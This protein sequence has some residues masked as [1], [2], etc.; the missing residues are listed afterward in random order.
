MG[1]PKFVDYTRECMNEI[2]YCPQDTLAYCTTDKYAGCPFYKT[3]EKIGVV[4]ENMRQC[5]VCK[6][7]ST[8]NFEQFVVMTAAYCL[9]DKFVECQRYI[10]K[11]QG[12]VVSEL[13]LPDGRELS[14]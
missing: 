11:K 5:P 3:V 9:N 14:R 2:G 10:L 1:C 4:C 12:R 8:H 6:Y 7:F 13:L